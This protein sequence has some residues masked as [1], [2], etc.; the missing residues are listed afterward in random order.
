MTQVPPKIELRDDQII[1]SNL[2]IRLFEASDYLHQLPDYDREA[3][4]VKAFEMGFFCLQRTENLND[5]QFVKQQ[6][7]ALLNVRIQ[8]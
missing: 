2:Q 8:V 1:I 4:C 6:F 3:A 7:N 5:T